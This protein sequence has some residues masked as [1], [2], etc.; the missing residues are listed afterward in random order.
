MSIA[1]YESKFIEL[2]RYAPHI[3]NTDY[4]KARKFEDGLN[5]E[6]LDRINVLKLLKYVD[7]LDRAIMAESNIDALK[8]T[9]TPATK[10]RG[11]R[12]GFKFKKGQNS[13][14]NKKQ[15]TGATT[16]SN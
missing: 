13:S 5:V 16:S 15:N 1:E 7:V 3:V 4:K 6:I 12:R 11:R 2:A 10:W 14:L 9:E 8:Q